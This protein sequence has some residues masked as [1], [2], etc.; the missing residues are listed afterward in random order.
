MFCLNKV[1]QIHYIL[2]FYLNSVSP[3]PLLLNTKYNFNISN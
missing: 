3:S 1:N 2:K